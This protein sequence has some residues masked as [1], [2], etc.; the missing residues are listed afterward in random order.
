MAP[1][2]IVAAGYREVDVRLVVK[3]IDPIRIQAP[4]IPARHPHH[5]APLRRD[6]R[7]PITSKYRA[8]S[9]RRP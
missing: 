3:L 8:R 1:R 4:T 7:Y 6:R 5:A 2:E 9:R